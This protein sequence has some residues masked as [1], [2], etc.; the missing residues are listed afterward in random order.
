MYFNINST[1]YHLVILTFEPLLAEVHFAL[2]VNQK[3]NKFED[4][5]FQI[6]IWMGQYDHHSPRTDL[7]CLLTVELHNAHLLKREI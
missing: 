3:K 6:I 2:S 1:K 4:N 7:A 5:I